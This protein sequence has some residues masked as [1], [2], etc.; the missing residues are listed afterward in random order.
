MDNVRRIVDE[1]ELLAQI[2]GE[3]MTPAARARVEAALAGDP[4]LRRRIE[5][6]AADRG[7]LLELAAGG[8]GE[9]PAPVGLVNAAM[10]RAVVELDQADLLRLVGSERAAPTTIPV[11][12][13]LPNR[14]AWW[15]DRR[16][17]GVLAAAACLAIVGAVIVTLRHGTRGATPGHGGG[18]LA[19]GPGGLTPGIGVA[20][21]PL[22]E[23]SGDRSQ[24]GGGSTDAVVGNTNRSGPSTS[25]ALNNPGAGTSAGNDQPG[26]SGGTTVPVAAHVNPEDLLGLD[27]DHAVRLAREGRLVLRVVAADAPRVE[28]RIA[29]L[30]D[31]GGV[32][33]SVRVAR[34]GEASAM[35]IRTTVADVLAVF[36]ADRARAHGTTPTGPE[37]A[38]TTGPI[39]ASA[40]P[41]P[42]AGGVNPGGPSTND[43]PSPAPT[44]AFDAS[45]ARLGSAAVVNAA[46]D[47]A[48]LRSAIR[49]LAG[50]GTGSGNP[51][52]ERAIVQAVVLAQP[53]NLPETIDS[54][55]VTWWRQPVSQWGS[56]IRVPVVVERRDSERR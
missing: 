37:V 23:R 41:R 12:A 54:A 52:G 25:V 27:L 16:V 46:A 8:A 6:M 24:A 7:G 31:R 38:A 9:L 15:A 2:E 33:P 29:R 17:T 3:A 5:S 45:L 44:P 55:S 35:T 14:R 40:H 49:A 20:Q 22:G 56:A 4:A 1:A 36:A 28:A 18:D 43:H 11:S 39:W 50:A 13:V 32:G 42:S 34:A 30:T 21:G 51:A 48:S 10:R 26:A 19:A 47:A 53:L